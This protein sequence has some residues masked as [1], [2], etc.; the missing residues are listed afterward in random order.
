MTKWSDI[1]G[2]LMDTSTMIGAVFVAVLWALA[3]IITGRAVRL[4]IH[5]YLD[6]TQRAGAA[7]TGIRFLGQLARVVVYILAFVGYAHVVPA[8]QKLGTASLAIGGAASVVVGLAAQSTLGNLIAGVSIVLYRPFKLGD[9]L[10]VFLPSGPET[11]VVE[12][13]DLGYTTL[14]AADKRRLVIP[15]NIMASQ[16]CVDLS[17]LPPR[18]SCNVSFYV[19]AGSDLDQARKI[20]LDAAKAHQ[21]I[22][23][24]DGC[25]L[26]RVTSKGAIVTLAASCADPDAAPGVVS[27]LLQEAKKKFD[28][29]GVKIA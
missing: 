8:L 19:A 13:I 2:S 27:D 3:A 22:A 5:R 26:T 18:T 16:A 21:Q 7:P 20:L 1:A 15:N 28:A 6:R 14:R 9:R 25:Y 17:L 11:G 4:A 23:Q 29:A 24:I 12:N 10:R